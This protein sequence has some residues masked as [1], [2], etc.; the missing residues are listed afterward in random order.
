[1]RIYYEIDNLEDH[2]EFAKKNPNCFKKDFD[3]LMPASK[4]IV[5]DSV[6][7]GVELRSGYLEIEIVPGLYEVL[8]YEQKIQ[9]AEIVFHKFQLH[10][11]M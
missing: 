6:V 1:V 4:M 5:F 2:I 9:D 8:P 7:P 3:I 11:D 10:R